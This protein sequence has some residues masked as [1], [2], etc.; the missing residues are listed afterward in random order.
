MNHDV[1]VILRNTGLMD[2]DHVFVRDY[3]D[4]DWGEPLRFT[5]C[6]V[7]VTEKLNE[8]RCPHG[9]CNF[10]FKLGRAVKSGETIR[11][12]YS[13]NLNY[14]MP[15][16]YFSIDAINHIK[17]LIVRVPRSFNEWS[18]RIEDTELLGSGL[19]TKHVSNKYNILVGKNLMPPTV[20][21]MR[22]VFLRI[23]V[24]NKAF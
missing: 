2:M 21:K 24:N 19:T 1:H 23:E 20:L 9:F 14:Y 16:D 7:T 11:Y 4:I 8:I 22:L 12:G 15:M 3:G 13:F 17:R 5:C 18:I 6:G 10:I